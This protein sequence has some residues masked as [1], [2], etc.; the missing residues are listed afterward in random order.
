MFCFAAATIVQTYLAAEEQGQLD[1]TAPEY[2]NRKRG[3]P[4]LDG[5]VG[6]IPTL[7]REGATTV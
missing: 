3:G 5:G 6:T 7:P 4:Q 2:V 1:P